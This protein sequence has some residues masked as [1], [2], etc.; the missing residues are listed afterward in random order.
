MNWWARLIASPGGVP[1]ASVGGVARRR[2][3]S[4]PPHRCCSSSV[5]T[6]QRQI[7]H[8]QPSSMLLINM[9]IVRYGKPFFF[10]YYQSA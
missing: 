8:W 1:A 3:I 2:R 10:V 6:S 5:A 7:N 4:A 9:S